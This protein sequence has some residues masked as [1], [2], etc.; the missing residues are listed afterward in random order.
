MRVRTRAQRVGSLDVRRSREWP[1]VARPTARALAD[2]ALAGFSGALQR[3][4][5]P[6]QPQLAR[7]PW[8]SPNQPSPLIFTMAFS[9]ASLA[10]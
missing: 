7:R 6:F 8:S 3:G 5:R 1:A 4:A 2:A 9:G 10:Y